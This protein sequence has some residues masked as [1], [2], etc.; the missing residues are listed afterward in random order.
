MTVYTIGIIICAA[1]ALV[2][3]AAYV[4]VRLAMKEK[5]DPIPTPAVDPNEVAKAMAEADAARSEAAKA[6][7][8]ADKARAEADK[9]RAD[10]DKARADADAAA[11]N[12]A[13]AI[14]KANALAEE[15]AKAA[16]EAKAK[17][18]EDEHAKRIAK[19]ASL[20]AEAEAELAI[21]E[22]LLAKARE[23]RYFL[24][25]KNEN[26]NHEAAIAADKLSR[27]R[28]AKFEALNRYGS[29][30]AAKAEAED[31]CDMATLKGGDIEAVA[32]ELEAA[33]AAE[34]EARLNLQD[35]YAAIIV[36][37]GELEKATAAQ[38][39]ADDTVLEKDVQIEE[40]ELKVKAIKARIEKLEA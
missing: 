12:T 26:A 1:I 11:V 9:A 5:N 35:A 17:L 27:A 7:A 31:A 36:A 10:A 18:A 40:F 15:A 13:E 30:V 3:L 38:K 14:A 24:N 21:V 32:K 8:E 23:D 16:A 28:T 2:L 19:N 34:R 6:K 33:N 37:E 22:T 25:G 39:A 4:V 20:I 29:A